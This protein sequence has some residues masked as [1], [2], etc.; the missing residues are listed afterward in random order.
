MKLCVEDMI[1]GRMRLVGTKVR[2]QDV[3]FPLI[4]ISR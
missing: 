3:A 4:P 2:R 1:S